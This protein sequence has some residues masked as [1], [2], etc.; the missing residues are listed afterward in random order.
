MKGIADLLDSDMEEAVP[1]IDENSILSS[2]SDATDATTTKTAQ[3]KRGKKRQRVTMPTKVK[4]KVQKGAP[5]E[6]K[7]ASSRQTAGVKR[8]AVE[9]ASNDQDSTGNLDESLRD[10]EAEKQPIAPKA[11]RGKRTN[12]KV[13]AA[14]E[15]VE[16][17]ENEDQLI[18][19]SPVA[20]RS[21]H[22]AA[23][24]KKE[25]PKVSAKATAPTKSKAA[26]Q[27][28]C[29]VL[30]PQHDE[31]EEITEELEVV[32]APK[33]RA[34]A[35]DTS[36]TRQDPPYRRR[37]GS[38][39]DT[40]RGDPNLRRKLGDVTRKFENVDLKYR[41]LKEVGIH[42]AN[43]NMEKLRKQCDATIQASDDLVASLKKE[44][45]T[46]A[47]LAHEARKLRKQIQNQ[48][49]E[50]ERMRDAA[51][52][53]STSLADAQNEIKGLQAKLVAARASSVDN[54]KPPSS[55][56]KSTAQRHFSGEAAQATQVAQMKEE[57]Y[58]DLTGLVILNV[59][60]TEE[61]DTY[62]C[63]QTGR[64]GTLHF[65]L[66]ID[67]EIAKGTSFE[68]TEYLYTPLLDRDRDH[69]MMKLM[70]SYLTEDITFARHNAAK[71]YG[72]VVDTITKK[73]GDE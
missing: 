13:K 47:P 62:E 66:F 40:E 19:V 59:K 34:I 24:T 73:R 17:V 63:I 52:Q 41:N 22:A 68:E 10:S 14:P 48:E 9:D 43:A 38:A 26:S 46:Q 37:A 60:K 67:Q 50:M 16:A 35:R 45:A 2:A 51:L 54:P 58:S 36:R 1:F 57:L 23:R 69:E 72:R 25:A 32:R 4:S 65:R 6:T 71:F 12:N 27:P 3:G 7:K 5:S 44:L 70:P 11:K 29:V 21:K 33:G 64:N 20:V 55:A 61:G 42:E 56:M 8:K 49:A 18:E 39:S 28:Q 15:A 31:T 30:E 53:L